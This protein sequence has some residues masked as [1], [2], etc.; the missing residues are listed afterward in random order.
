MNREAALGP[1]SALQARERFP[2]LQRIE[3]GLL[4]HRSSNSLIRLALASGA[5]QDKLTAFARARSWKARAD[6]IVS[7]IRESIARKREEGY[8]G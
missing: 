7:L 2:G 3:R 8:T 1:P 4:S 6:E 5:N